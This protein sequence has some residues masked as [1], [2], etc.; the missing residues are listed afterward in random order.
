[1]F[2]HGINREYA[3]KQF[4]ILSPRRSLSHKTEE[5]L[6]DRLHLIRQFGLEPLHLL[7]ASEDYPEETCIQSCLHFG[8]TVFAFAALQAPYWQLSMHELAVP[9]LDLRNACAIF[10]T[11]NDIF[12]LKSHLPGIP[13]TIV[14]KFGE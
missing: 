13:I 11:L 7:E 2:Y 3:E 6:S 5:Q 12:R 14:E 1:M 9:I 10:T 8:D 4:P